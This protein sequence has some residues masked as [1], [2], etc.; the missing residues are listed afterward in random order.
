MSYGAVRCDEQPAIS[1]NGRDGTGRSAPSASAARFG[2]T[3]TVHSM[4]HSAIES[5]E[6]LVS[7]SGSSGGFE[8]AAPII[9]ATSG[10]DA[11][12]ARAMRRG[13]GA[14]PTRWRTG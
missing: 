9:S 13:T 11:Q 8:P 14:G 7:P 2:D 3:R 10:S 5:D 4:S 12:T 1:S 6:R